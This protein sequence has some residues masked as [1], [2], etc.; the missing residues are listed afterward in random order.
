MSKKGGN[1]NAAG[2]LT[3]KTECWLV[4][5]CRRE[6]LLPQ[7]WRVNHSRESAHRQ[8]RDQVMMNPDADFG[9]KDVSARR[10]QKE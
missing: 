8:K 4:K 1:G 6:N 9:N 7:F 2:P 10:N 3:R 5:P